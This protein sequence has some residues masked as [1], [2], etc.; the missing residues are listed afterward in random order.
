MKHTLDSA[1]VTNEGTA[2]QRIAIL[3]ELTSKS[4][5]LIGLLG[6][7]VQPFTISAQGFSKDYIGIVSGERDGKHPM[8]AEEMLALKVPFHP[9]AL[10]QLERILKMDTRGKTAAQIRDEAARV[11]S[12]LPEGHNLRE[13]P[14]SFADR[15]SAIG[16]YTAVRQALFSLNRSTTGGNMAT[17]KVKQVEGE[18]PANTAATETPKDATAKDTGGKTKA[19]EGAKDTAKAAKAKGNGR[20]KADLSGKY[21][22]AGDAAKAKT[23]EELGMHEDSV[24]TKVLAVVMKSKAKNG[25]DFTALEEAGKEQTRGAVA[26]LVKRGFLA[27]TA[28]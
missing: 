27:K 26:Y 23:T 14:K 11:A 20:A 17:K 13:V 8:W 21:V 3:I 6:K 2:K 9:A 18:A 16:F 12:D 24:R 22:L 4:A 15:A 19:S 1:Y 25:V 10:D 7:K 5:N 28:A